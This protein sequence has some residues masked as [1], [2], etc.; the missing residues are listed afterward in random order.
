MANKARGKQYMYAEH[1]EGLQLRDVSDL[2]LGT[3]A[4]RST[5]KFL[6]VLKYVDFIGQGIY[7]IQSIV[8]M[9]TVFS[10]VRNQ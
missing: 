7:Y 8:H 2:R 6:W 1:C 3:M 10:D 4:V 9:K 5:T